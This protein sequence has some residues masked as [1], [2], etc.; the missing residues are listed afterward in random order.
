MGDHWLGWFLLGIVDRMT[1]RF[2]EPSHKKP[3]IMENLQKKKIINPGRACVKDVSLVVS[4]TGI[5]ACSLPCC[6]LGKWQSLLNFNSWVEG[7]APGLIVRALKNIG[8]CQVPSACF[9][10]QNHSQ[11]RCTSLY[12]V[13]CICWVILNVQ[14]RVLVY[15]VNSFPLSQRKYIIIIPSIPRH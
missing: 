9:M 10:Q 11:I 7:L 1:Q 4:L 5:L 12:C 6:C 13:C 15:F 8:V 2:S 14:I 3:C